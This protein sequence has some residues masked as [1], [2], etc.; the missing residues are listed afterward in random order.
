MREE[1]E[2]Q[3]E[4]ISAACVRVSTVISARVDLQGSVWDCIP[5]L[6]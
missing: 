3:V 6:L 5:I 4:V 2:E 1:R